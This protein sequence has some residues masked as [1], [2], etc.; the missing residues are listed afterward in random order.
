M[1]ILYAFQGTGNGHAARARAILP[2]LARYAQ[3]DVATSG[4]NSQLNIGYPIAHRYRGISYESNG[5]GRISYLKT[6]RAFSFLRAVRDVRSVPLSSY[7]LVVNDFE[8]I[9]AFAARRAGVPSLAVSHQASFLSPHA[10]RPRRPD[11]LAEGVFKWYA[12]AKSALGF[13]FERYDTNILTP[14]LRSEIQDVRGTNEGHVTVYLPGFDEHYL[15]NILQC[16]A[17]KKVHIF[18]R[19]VSTVCQYGNVTIAP[20]AHED[21]VR[22]LVSCD[23]FLAGA[24]FE[25][26]AEAL[27]LGKKLMVVPLGGQY[28]QWCN[29]AA[30]SRL[31]VPVLERVTPTESDRIRDWAHSKERV[32]IRFPNIMGELIERVLAFAR[33]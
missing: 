33:S 32:E 29:A 28:E 20:I 9:T 10:P 3:V 15:S 25:G 24:G 17:P 22:S 4:M 7:D 31:H 11:Y 27:H 26:P 18:S 5:K 1:R 16:L 19:G 13:H 8:P 6:I 23:A 21:F 30:L 12:P 2:E 14:L